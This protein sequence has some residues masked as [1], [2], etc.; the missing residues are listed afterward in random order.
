MSSEFRI[1]RRLV[2]PELNTI[3]T[4]GK[5]TRVEPKVME[6][7]V[8]LAGRPG[9]VVQR[10]T[11]IRDLWGDTFVTDAALTR[12]IAEL[13]KL[14][15]D[16]VRD[17]RVIQTIAKS[18]YRLI[19]AVEPADGDVPSIAA[20]AAAIDGD[21]A[22]ARGELVRRAAHARA[23]GSEMMRRARPASA[24]LLALVITSAAEDR[25]PLER[26]ISTVVPAVQP[27]TAMERVRRIYA[28]DRWFTFPK[29][30]ETTRYLAGELKRLGLEQV[31]IAGAPADGVTQ[32]GYWTMPLAWD[33]R[34][35]T[36]ELV[37]EDVMPEFRVLADYQK[38]P[39][40]LGMWSAPTPPDG[41]TADIVEYAEGA[42]LRGKLVLTKQNSANLKWRLA[43]DGALGAINTFTENPK[44]ENGRQWINAWGDNG[45]AFT[46]QSSRLLSFSITP[47]QAAYVRG[48][49]AEGKTVR[50]RA[51][52]DSRYYKGTYPYVTGVLRGDPGREEVLLLGHSSEQGAQD[53][54]TGVAAMLEA[55][56]ALQR[57]VASGKLPRPRR[58]IRLLLMG[59]MY[60]SMHYVAQNQDRIRD[61][62]AAMCVDTPA[63]SYDLPGTEYTFYMNPHVASSYT[64]ALVLE[65]AAAYFPR[66]GRPWHE[67]AYMS[68]TD[69]YLA[70]P[71][72]GIPTVWPY[73]GPG[74]QTH[75]N[76]E[77]KPEHVD[78]RSLR[79]LAVVT[80]TYLYTIATSG[81]S[82]AAWLS[83][84][85][86]HRGTRRME[87]AIARGA[88]AVG[89]ETDRAA[90]AIRSVERLVP[91]ERRAALAPQLD[92]RVRQL[93][94]AKAAQPNAPAA[95]PDAARLVVKRKR[96][97]TIPLDEISPA[98]RRGFPSGAWAAE[99]IAALYWCDGRRTPA[100]V[101]R[102]TQLE[103]GPSRL[104][105]V[106]YFRFLAERGYVE[107]IE[108]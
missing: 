53:N 16:D 82:E 103:L 13:R 22:P 67:H 96:F 104:D 66:V 15:D 37:G 97:G 84:L 91:R 32:V 80:A 95:S 94:V 47:R 1:G 12:C 99:P 26:T 11:L 56:G 100:E 60:G 25:S 59:E 108:R 41:V 36:L 73:S 3:V 65:I 14:F 43:R 69:T 54:A 77:D 31:E 57:L 58:T 79:D 68:G 42:D 4:S 8:Y 23:A 70:D 63:A 75:H 87:A 17:P 46:A 7:L 5:E 83:D 18:G 61:T 51:R 30:E 52:V 48:R 20:P 39:T 71:M 90:Q 19:A 49:L 21:R 28:T 50:A 9:Q 89:Y 35:A 81:E 64:D 45:W 29:F 101:I 72:I 92:A 78:A 55:V 93:A 24:L 74:I 2:Q 88:D 6:V 76:S 98:D 85:A 102:L 106:G 38:V 62:V 86:L 33:A 10:E 40:S 107:L 44:L 105:F 34:S 27:D